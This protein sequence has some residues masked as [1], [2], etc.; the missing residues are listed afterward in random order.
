MNQF[1]EA[2]KLLRRSHR[3][4]SDLLELDQEVQLHGVDPQET[5]SEIR[6]WIEPHIAAR[7]PR[8]PSNGHL[9]VFLP[10]SF[11]HPGRQRSILVH[12]ATMGF[13][14]LN[15]TYPNSWTV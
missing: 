8:V 7:D 10:G 13:A 1:S 9:L 3:R 5:D 4:Q 2:I 14:A 6:E 12:A 11:G 15:I